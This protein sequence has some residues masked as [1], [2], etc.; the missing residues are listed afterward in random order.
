MKEKII[1]ASSSPRRKELLARIIPDFEVVHAAVSEAFA[2]GT[3]PEEIVI[4]NAIRKAREVSSKY[5]DAIVIGADTVV[6]LDGTILEKPANSDEAIKMLEALSDRKHTV[7]TGLAVVNARQGIEL[8]K[9]DK[10]E[11]TFRNL[12]EKAIVDYVAAGTCLDKAG[13]YGIQDVGGEFVETINGNIDNVIGLP[14]ELLSEMLGKMGKMM[15][16][17]KKV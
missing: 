10:T 7:I 17:D 11:V 15:E 8:T 13:A 1:L 12:S 3:E 5:P 2:E 16:R 4:T 14:L 9:I 6:I